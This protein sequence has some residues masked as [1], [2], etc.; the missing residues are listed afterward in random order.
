MVEHDMSDIDK[1]YELTKEEYHTYCGS[2]LYRIRALK[3]FSDVKK[4]D[5]GGWVETEANLSQHNDCWIY[6]DA[7]VYDNAHVEDNSKLY[8]RVRVSEDASIVGDS[9][10]TE[11]VKIS[12]NTIIDSS[13]ITGDFIVN[14]HHIRIQNTKVTKDPIIILGLEYTVVIT[15]EHVTCGCQQHTKEEWLSFKYNDIFAM[16]RYDAV[17][18]YNNK[19]VHILKML[20]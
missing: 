10:L 15:D 4:G 6:D 17:D 5:L 8:N 1:K 14:Y 12:G 11:Y 13:I 3:D 18:F 20:P 2:T 7:K 9:K 16:D 19:L